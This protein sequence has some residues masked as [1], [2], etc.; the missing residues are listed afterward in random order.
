MPFSLCTCIEQRQAPA[1]LAGVQVPAYL[2]IVSF[3]TY[4]RIVL[5]HD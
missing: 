5:H 3:G 1:H 2:V 4:Y